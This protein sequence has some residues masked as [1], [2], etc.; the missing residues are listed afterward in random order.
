[1]NFISAAQKLIWISIIRKWIAD[2][3]GAKRK[4]TDP[5]DPKAT[6]AVVLI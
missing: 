3:E 2:A 6:D 5:L 1:M 4:A